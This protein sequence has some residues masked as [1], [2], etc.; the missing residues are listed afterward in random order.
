MGYPYLSIEDNIKQTLSEAQAHCL[1]NENC[2]GVTEMP[3][4]TF[5]TR[6]GPELNISE[7]GEISYLKP[8][9][10]GFEECFSTDIG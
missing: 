6:A 2:K 1:K 5:E 4:D 9:G 3:D 10:V 7:I 8:T